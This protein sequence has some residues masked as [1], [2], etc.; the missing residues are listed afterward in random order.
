[1]SE[2]ASNPVQAPVSPVTATPA[3]TEVKS[4]TAP[5]KAAAPEI[6]EVKVNGKSVRMT[7]EEVLN[8]ASMSHAAQGKF[9]EA[10]KSRKQAESLISRMKSDPISA[11]LDPAL[12]LSKDQVREALENWYSKEYIEPETLSPQERKYK[13]M[14]QRLKSFEQSEKDKLAKAQKEQED[15]ITNNQKE[16]LQK[17]ITDAIDGSGLPR[18][19]FIAQRMAYYMRQN[20]INGW[21]A[22]MGVIVDQ[23]KKERREM[24]S[25]LTEA[26]DGDTLISMLGEGVVK[27]IQKHALEKLRQSREIRGASPEVRSNPTPNGSK[28]R[29]TSGQVAENLRLMRQG[30]PPKY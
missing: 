27:K 1:M 12:G 28:E 4:A 13:E 5:S 16:H 11:L 24:M 10:A 18:T 21:E 7:K 17:Q 26:S 6:F 3:Q 19:K 2:Q 20:L 15:K 23:V 30:K 29:L 9:E 14:E 8:H 25:D 22:P